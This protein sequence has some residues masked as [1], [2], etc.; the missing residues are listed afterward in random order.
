MAEAKRAIDL[1]D[2]KN[3]SG[4]LAKAR[5]YSLSKKKAEF[6]AIRVKLGEEHLKSSLPHISSGSIVVDYLIGGMINTFGVA[7]CPG[8]PGGRVTQI[9]GAEAAGKTTLALSAAAAVC[10]RGGSV[11]YVDWENDIVPDYAYKLGVPITDENRFELLQPD[12][13]E[14]GIKYALI[15]AAAGVDFIVFD[16]VGAA[17]PR[18]LADRDMSEAAEQA[19]IGELQLIWSQELPNLKRIAARTGTTILGISQTRADIGSQHGGMKPQ[20]GNGWKFYSSVRLELRKV[21]SESAKEMNALTHTVEEKVFGNIVKCKAVKCKMSASQGR[22]EILYIRQ[23]HGVDNIRTIIEIAVA[24]G[25]IKKAGS[26][27]TWVKPDGSAVK[28]QSIEKLRTA[29]IA[30]PEDFVLLDSIVRPLLGSGKS[31]S[32]YADEDSPVAGEDEASEDDDSGEAA[33]KED[34][35]KATDSAIENLS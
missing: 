26:W 18:R 30:K 23:G 20:G 16:S 14:D 2:A 3:N 34:D 27:V 35:F 29:L 32:Q 6:E 4:A 24:H 8:F 9:W 11:L 1:Y 5:A 28:V 12:H 13:L 7:P 22:E 10:K 15:Y 33:E 17:M 21:S 31:A 19:K 25:L